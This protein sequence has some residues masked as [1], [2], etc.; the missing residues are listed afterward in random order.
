VVAR[1]TMAARKIVAIELIIDSGHIG[2]C[3]LEHI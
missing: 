2:R 1:F 3:V